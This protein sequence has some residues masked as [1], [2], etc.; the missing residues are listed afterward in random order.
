LLRIFQ[1]LDIT[2]CVEHWTPLVLQAVHNVDLSMVPNALRSKQFL[3]RLTLLC[4][5]FFN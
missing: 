4:L 1:E 5:G 2:L 3:K